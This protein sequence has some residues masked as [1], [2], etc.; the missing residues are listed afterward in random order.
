MLAWFAW[1]VLIFGI[2]YA[3]ERQ[4]QRIAAAEARAALEAR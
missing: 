1:G 4:H 2:R 3:V